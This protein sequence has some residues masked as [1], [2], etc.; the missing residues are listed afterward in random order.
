MTGTVLT[1]PQCVRV[2]G[3]VGDTKGIEVL[4][5]R[6]VW[7]VPGIPLALSTDIRND[8]KPI[9]QHSIHD[10]L[11]CQLHNTTTGPTTNTVDSTDHCLVARRVHRTAI[12]ESIQLR[13]LHHA[14]SVVDRSAKAIV[15]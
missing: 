13:P 2:G 9:G 11:G 10:L 4:K 8:I 6:N 12:D 5:E 3:L 7:Q 1:F 15:V 14:P